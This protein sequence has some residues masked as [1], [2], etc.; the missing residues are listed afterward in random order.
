MEPIRTGIC[1]NNK[2]ECMK[3]LAS[4]ICAASMLAGCASHTGVVDAGGGEYM[5]ARQAATGFPGLG[6]LKADILTEAAAHCR[7]TG[8]QMLLTG[9]KESQPPYIF[10]NFPRAEIRFRC[11]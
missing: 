4:V 6:T 1:A 8:K 5:V 9:E 2:G 11:K 3:E 7:A 10:G